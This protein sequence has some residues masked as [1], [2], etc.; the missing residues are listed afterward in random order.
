MYERLNNRLQENHDKIM[1]ASVHDKA[2][3]IRCLVLCMGTKGISILPW[4]KKLEEPLISMDNRLGGR[5]F[6]GTSLVFTD[7]SVTGI[8]SKTRVLSVHEQESI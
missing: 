7:R 5:R 2:I 1:V 4:V 8:H 6:H 3:L